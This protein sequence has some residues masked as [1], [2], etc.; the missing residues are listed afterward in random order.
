VHFAIV[1]AGSVGGFIG[2][3]IARA[4]GHVT[5]I[6]QW[7]QHIDAIKADGIHIEGTSGTFTVQMKALHIHE[8][9]SLISD[10][11]D[12]ALI[13]V[14]SYDSD[15]STALIKDYLSPRGFVVSVQNSFNE[16]KM[17][18][19]VGWGRVLGCILNTIGVEL[20][21]P[22]KILRW[23]KPSTAD[24]AVFRVGEM[25]GRPTERAQAVADALS[26]AD[27]AKVTTNLWGE[28]WSKLTINSLGSGTAAVTGIGLADMYLNDQTRLLALRLGQEAIQV[29]MAQGYE[30]EPIC[31]VSPQTWA[32][33]LGQIHQRPEYRS[34]D[35]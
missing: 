1:G 31:G 32:S 13:C 7:P 34:P 12:V 25:H 14:K 16:E 11:V 4:G 27:V 30:L 26:V 5:L 17:A 18:K 29:G 33:D 6:D 28:R 23:Y 21:A 3:Q 10:P 24:Y 22:G 20:T 19:I 9:Q 8:V 15:W 35:A 2:A